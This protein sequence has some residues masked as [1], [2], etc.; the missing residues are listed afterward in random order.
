MAETETLGAIQQKIHEEA[1]EE[2]VF[3]EVRVNLNITKTQN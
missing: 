1:K 2:G 3:R